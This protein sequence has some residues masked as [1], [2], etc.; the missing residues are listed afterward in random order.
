MKG[1][2]GAEKV[3]LNQVIEYS[4]PFF[5]V[6]A[7]TKRTLTDEMVDQNLLICVFLMMPVDK[8][9]LFVHEKI[10]N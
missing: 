6:F 4:S 3:G 7:S 10:R 8:I 2:L 9:R 1:T 5:C